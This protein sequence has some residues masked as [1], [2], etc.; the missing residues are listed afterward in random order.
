MHQ[1][2]ISGKLL[3]VEIVNVLSEKT[4]GFSG[5]VFRVATGKCFRASFNQFS[6]YV[7]KQQTNTK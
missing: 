3:S 1:I 6:F 4:D 7:P 5:I 2:L